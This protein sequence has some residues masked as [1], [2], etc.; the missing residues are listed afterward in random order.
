MVLQVTIVC[1]LVVDDESV[2]VGE[3]KLHVGGS[4]TLEGETEAVS[5]TA[6]LN[7][8]MPVTVTVDCPDC[9]GAEMLTE[10]GE[11]CKVIAVPTAT[12]TPGD[13]EPT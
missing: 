9:P 7:P 13:V 3:A 1:W 12:V 6:P 5:V 11:A 8:L 2:S 10:V 4:L